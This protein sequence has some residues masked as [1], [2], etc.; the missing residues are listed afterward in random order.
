MHAL[1]H[2]SCALLNAHEPKQEAL[3][4]EVQSSAHRRQN[5]DASE[6]LVGK[7]GNRTAVGSVSHHPP[8]VTV[9]DRRRRFAKVGWMDGWMDGMTR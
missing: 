2:G 9:R 7:H 3:T 6:A 8:S 5:C 1:A 4:N